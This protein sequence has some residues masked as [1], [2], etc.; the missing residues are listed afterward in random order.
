MLLC[1][2]LIE[3]HLEF[4]QELRSFSK[5]LSFGCFCVTEAVRAMS[6]SESKSPS[7]RSN[8]K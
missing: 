7:N 8:M 2:D 4:I 6:A 5:I 3:F 1:H